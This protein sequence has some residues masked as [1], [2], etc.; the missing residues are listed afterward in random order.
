MPA[1]ATPPVEPE[2]AQSRYASFLLRLWWEE[3]Q[4]QWRASVEDARTGERRAFASVARLMA[5]LQQQTELPP[6]PHEA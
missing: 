2:S 5:F 1:N 3:G 4:Q 6:P